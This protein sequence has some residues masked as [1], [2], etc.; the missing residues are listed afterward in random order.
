[1][2]EQIISY[3]CRKDRCDH[4]RRYCHC[5]LQLTNQLNRAVQLPRYLFEM[6]KYFN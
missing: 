2:Y 3:T 1:M 4:L 5:S 6:T